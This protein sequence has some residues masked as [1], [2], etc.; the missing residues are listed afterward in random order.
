[1]SEYCKNCEAL[2]EEIRTLKDQLMETK[3]FDLF[4]EKIME[5]V[6]T[7]TV[8]ISLFQ[9]H[10]L[11]K[12]ALEEIEGLI[13]STLDDFEEDDEEVQLSYCHNISL[14]ILDIISKAKGEE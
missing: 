11:Y 3:T 8:L 10:K 4:A 1:M 14:Q 13:Q 7:D 9:K 12:Q 5:K 2:K 6:N